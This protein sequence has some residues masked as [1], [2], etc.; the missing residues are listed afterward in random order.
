[1]TPALAFRGSLLHLLRDPG[2]A[3]AS[4]AARYFE[5]GVLV[6]RD[7]RIV[8]AGSAR[9]VLARLP[10]DAA[11]KDYSGKLLV[12]GFVDCHIHYPQTDM[13]A[14][15]GAQLLEWLERYTF[16]TERRFDDPGHAREVA[17]FFLDELLRNGTTT[18]LVLG[19]VH[20]QSVDAIF[21][22]SRVRGL[23]MIAGKVLMDRN[24]PEY[25]RDTAR[26]GYAE[27]RDLIERWHGRDRL[28]YAVTPRFAPTSSAEQL[29]GAGRLAEEF[30][31]VYVHT[32]LAENRSE[33]AW[34][35]ELFP[36]SRSYLD[37]YAGFGLVRRRSVFAHC[38]HLDDAE[39]RLMAERGASAAFCPASNL[40]LGSGLLDLRR[41]REHAIA[42]G[43]GTDVGAGT[44]FSM[45]RTMQEAY[46]VARLG[47]QALPP[48]Q[49][50]YLAT[51]GGAQALDLAD[52]IGNFEPGKEA[53]FVVVDLAATPLLERRLRQARDLAEKLFAWIMLGDDRSVVATYAS[54]KQVY[55]ACGNSIFAC[56]EGSD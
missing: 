8:E 3:A 55:S 11:V 25:L 35:K 29:E 49:A 44:S 9:D 41:T 52:R 27:S 26:S 42:V 46:K 12:P 32:H 17:D 7:G 21:E 10:A 33:V 6:V 19:T 18:A 15:H 5:D 4:D 37:V 14:S 53:D 39:R 36:S 31:G 38:I 47:G 56:A 24:C 20:P 23:R 43:L 54:G 22:A 1:M 16:P 51:L 50:L 28:L 30:P 40:F 2:D 48:Y 13:I 45:L 34:V